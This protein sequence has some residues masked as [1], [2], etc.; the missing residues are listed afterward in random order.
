MAKAYFN[1]KTFE[2]ID[3]QH[4]FES[5]LDELSKIIDKFREK[6]INIFFY[7]NIYQISLAISQQ[8]FINYICDP[9]SSLD[10]DLV[11]K[12]IKYISDYPSFPTNQEICIDCINCEQEHCP[13]YVC[14][15][16]KQSPIVSLSNDSSLLE[17]TYSR[18][19]IQISNIK[20]LTEIE[21][22]LNKLTTPQHFK[23]MNEVFS[24]LEN[25]YSDK[26]Y[27]TP[28]AKKSIRYLQSD[29]DLYMKIY[30]AIDGIMNV[31]LP[32]NNDKLSSN[33]IEEYKRETTFDVSPESKKTMNIPFCRE[34]RE[35]KIG[36]ETHIFNNHVKIGGRTPSRIHF[37]VK[38]NI[39]YI[40]HCGNHLA[41]SEN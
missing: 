39:L 9:S 29:T 3:N 12:I 5:A 21:D 18:G 32:S 28:Q 20:L 24:E 8:E 7:K 34:E 17:A 4:T 26:L 25:K 40:G 2:T 23:S 31:I 30:N 10:Y 22:W 19:G 6:G 14:E 1:H 11:Y 41:T 33:I 27:I 16:D 37:L 38:D 35:F 15:V 36:N 13:L